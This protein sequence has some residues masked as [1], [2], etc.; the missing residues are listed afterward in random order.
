MLV[1]AQFAFPSCEC[2]NAVAAWISAIVAAVALWAVF[3]QLRGLGSTLRLES[4]AKILDIE[5]DID[6]RR[7]LVALVS[8]K[9]ERELAKS[10]PDFAELD[11]LGVER[12]LRIESYPES[13][14]R[15]AFCIL[16]NQLG[17]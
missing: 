12:G 8:S 16:N 5:K 3:V 7:V 13:L 11:L 6:D 2:W 17:E 15:L 4:L 1:A 14:D 10:P 9:F